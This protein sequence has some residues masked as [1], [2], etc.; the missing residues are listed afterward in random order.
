MSRRPRSLRALVAAAALASLAL[1]ACGSSDGGSAAPTNSAGVT[2]VNPSKLTVCTHLP[3]KPFQFKDDSG[4]VVGFDV[5]MMDLLAKKL[6]VTQEIVDIDFA[7]MLSGAV[8]A[9]KKCD[10]AAGATTI[11]DKRRES[12]LFSDPYFD[13]TQALITKKG[14]GITDL[15]DLKGKK[16]GVQTDT[17]GQLY[18]EK[19][20]AANGYTVVVFDDSSTQLSGVLAG[21]VAAAINDNGAVFDFAKANPTTEVVKEFSTGEQYGF[22]FQKDNANG[23]KLAELMNEVIKTA[24]ADGTYNEI[25]KKWFGV[26]APK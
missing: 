25:F 1:A 3:Y 7:S 22:M 11:N 5:D 19:N 10:A 15:A 17:T 2:L 4:N 14:S 12:V 21:R 26:D 9:A 24:K 8:F 18:A 16:L 20:K 13:A 23:T 6:G